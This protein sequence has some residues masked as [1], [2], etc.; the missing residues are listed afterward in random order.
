M[1]AGKEFSTKNTDIV[2][3]LRYDH[4]DK[5]GL[6]ACILIFPIF[7]ITVVPSLIHSVGSRYSGYI[8]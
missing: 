5:L 3:I 8:W 4:V 6:L 1:P 7:S 2:E